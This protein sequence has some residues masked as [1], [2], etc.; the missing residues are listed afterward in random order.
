MSQK[1][2]LGE[3]GEM[4]YFYNEAI[5][6]LRTNITFS[7]NNVQTILFTSSV[8]GEGKSETSF[9]VSQAF[10]QIGKRVLYV[11][12]DIRKSMF[13]KRRGIRGETYGLSQYLSGQKE[14]RD[15]LYETSIPNLDVILAGPYSPNP[16]ELLEEDS[17]SDLLK[18]LKNTYDYII[19]DSPPMGGLI[20][21][22][23]IASHCD[24]A[25]LVIESGAISYRLLQK[26]KTQLQRS[27]CR[28]L[29]AALNKMDIRKHGK[30][31]SYYRYGKGGVYGPEQ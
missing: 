1:L 17:F 11:D 9:A 28:I 3:L 19:I 10:A 6:S 21:G 8:P 14:I 29:G 12:A 18:M 24:G 4:D 30:Y 25:I 27:N 31:Y 5:K 22:A 16:A 26:V 2:N 23:I 20:D 13:V 15:I 7:G